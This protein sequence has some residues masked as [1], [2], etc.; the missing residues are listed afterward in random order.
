M[1]NS[2]LLDTTV[3]IAHLRGDKSVTDK[4]LATDELFL[5]IVTV[6]ELFH[7]A[8]VLPFE[9]RPIETIKTFLSAVTV[10]ALTLE[11]AELF[12]GI[13]GELR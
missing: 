11:T 3:G 2:V 6:G 10:L 1:S 12:A 7:G 8:F 13:S 5:P 9:D 4:L